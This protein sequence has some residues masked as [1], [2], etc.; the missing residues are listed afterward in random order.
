MDDRSAKQGEPR[1]A[2]PKVRGA[3]PWTA[4]ASGP[5]RRSRPPGGS[6]AGGVT[7][8]LAQPTRG[9]AKTRFEPQGP[10]VSTARLRRAYLSAFEKDAADVAAGLYPPVESGAGRPADAFREA[11]DVI[12]DAR[13]VDQRRRRGD[14]VEVRETPESEGYPNYYR[15]NFHFQSGGW[16]TDASAR[17][18]EA[19]VEALFSGAAGAMCAA[20][21]RCWP[22]HW[23]GKDQRGLKL[24]DL[25]CGSGAFL[26]D[27]AAAFPRSHRPAWTCRGPTWP[28]PAAARA[29]AGCRP[30]PRPC[31]SPT[32][33]WTP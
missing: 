19:Q 2:I 8:A 32:P 25:A 26:G 5:R 15:Q 4:P 21:C 24:V 10:P 12:A 29:G 31:R 23:R 3:S 17:R 7:R 9:D 33:A 13:A 30:T 22:R 1:E 18:Y 28:P 16:F 27:L 6:A 20:P 11:L 14:G